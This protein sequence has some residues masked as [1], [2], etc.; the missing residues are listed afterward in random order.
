MPNKSVNARAVPSSAIGCWTKAMMQLRIE[1]K[2]QLLR[3]VQLERFPCRLGRGSANDVVLSHWRVGR[4]H[5]ELHRFDDGIRLID[6]GA[7]GGTRVNGERVEEFGPL[8]DFDRIEIAGFSLRLVGEFAAQ[9]SERSWGAPDQS[10]PLSPLGGPNRSASSTAPHGPKDLPNGPSPFFT[11][12]SL[13]HQAD[14]MHW[15]TEPD[16][17]RM[18]GAADGEH[19]K[20][21][22]ATRNAQASDP[23]AVSCPDVLAVNR[24]LNGSAQAPAQAPVHG[25]VHAPVDEGASRPING[26]LNES[27]GRS[28]A[29]PSAT[30]GVMPS[31]TPQ[32]FQA[33]AH[34]SVRAKDASAAPS[35]DALVL[36]WQRRLHRG[37]INAIDLR[38]HDVRQLSDHQLRTEVGAVLRNL[39]ATTH[40]PPSGLDPELLW[41]RVLDEAIGL[42]PLEPLLA[43]ASISEIMV[44]AA[45]AIWVE[46]SG[47]LEHH[48]ARFT[49]DD[50]IRAVIERIVAPLGRRIDESSPMVDARLADGSRVNAIIPPLAVRGPALTIRRFSRRLL[51]TDDL[52]RLGSASAQMLEFLRVCV[53]SRR[54]LIVSGGTGSGKTTLLNVLSNLIPQGERLIT[55]EDAAELRLAYPHLVTLEARPANLEGR[56]A[57]TIR[58]LVRNALRMRPDRIIVGECR[59]GEALDM[60]QAMNTGHE[61]S[62]TTVHANTARDALS[63]LE[64]MVLMA[65]IDLPIAVVREQ[66]AS[67]IDLVVHQVRGADGVRRI[68]SILEVTGIEAGRVQTQE[69]FRYVQHGGAVGA[70]SRLGGHFEACDAVPQFYEGLAQAGW[71]LDYQGFER[72][73]VR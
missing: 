73:G 21:V 43:D 24:P 9:D 10:A 31:V 48:S 42:G 36:E 2:G 65:G 70:E 16:L 60:L 67:A 72:E 49:D 57:V 14:P 68:Q 8:A 69:I 71:T 52:L 62:L 45:D 28:A 13:S 11:L 17:R 12:G 59:G 34:A 50:A 30:P 54:N 23:G 63:R 47:R 39:L 20:T 38:R 4:C 55:I 1:S 64:V 32:P 56:G 27:L 58:D 3:E 33:S 26:S 37:L 66:I 18:M 41:Q 44:N 25:P 40:V 15:L 29:T 51:G 7:F 19:S 61:G 22:V 35:N 6:R 53:A 5:A 46:R